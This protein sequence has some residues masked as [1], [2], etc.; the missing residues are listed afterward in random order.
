ML[1]EKERKNRNEEEYNSKTNTTI[2]LIQTKNVD[3]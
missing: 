1:R 3:E 2:K